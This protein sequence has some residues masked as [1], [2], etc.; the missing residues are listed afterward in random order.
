MRS[1][2]AAV[3]AGLIAVG[4]T[5]GM[6]AA[7]RTQVT[8][9][10]R[11]RVTAAAR[12]Q[13]AAGA[14]TRVTAGAITRRPAGVTAARPGRIGEAGLGPGQR[15]YV[16]GLTTGPD[17]AIWF[18]DLGC[19]GLGR[20]G[21]GRI[22]AGGY[23]L[24]TR[25]LNR[26]SVPFQ[27]ALGPDGNLWFTDE[28]AR[29]A[30]GRISVAGRIT[31]YSRGLPR[32]SNPFAITRGPGRAMWFTVQGRHPA[33]GHIDMRGR[34]TLR[35]R[36]LAR[37]ATPFGI[38]ALPSGI[39]FTDQG[40][41]TG[42]GCRIGRVTPAGA[43]HESQA[44]LRAGAHPLAIAAGFGGTAWFA[45]DSGAIGE[46]RADGTVREH[47]LAAGSAPVGIAPGP[48]GAIWFTD[49]GA[50]PHLGRVDPSGAV[51]TYADGLEP[52]SLPAA[53]APGAD[54]SLWFTDEGTTA[55]IGRVTTAAPAPVRHPPGLSGRMRVGST[56]AC[57]A[58]VMGAW[59]GLL[60]GT[61]FPYDGIRWLRDGK[62]VARGAGYR[63]RGRDAGHRLGCRD[64]LTY[65]PPLGVTAVIGSRTA[66]AGR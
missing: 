46:V 41:A 40:C 15:V 29:P 26:G 49:E 52:G 63:V 48:D 24:Y 62:V 5:A 9:G 6:T 38:A 30:I 28:G 60:P 13:V 16:F 22:A 51:R 59:A 58:P 64:T 43:I 3:L 55:A 35:H 50:S 32:G 21:I 45:D 27:I 66:R 25:G 44:G 20:C 2:L 47:A 36:G 34:I 39:W 17:G 37:R 14:R 42:G 12:T 31:E 4:A 11:T 19:A 10:A 18:A 7:A 8:A 57:R 56:L 61:P 54:G 53:I 33:I 1:L 23:A 65:P